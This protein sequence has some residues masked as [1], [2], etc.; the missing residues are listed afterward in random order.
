M[1]SCTSR[2]PFTKLYS[3]IASVAMSVAAAL[4]E[5]P[6]T[7]TLLKK[8]KISP[9]S[10]LL[11]FALPEHRRYLGSDPMLPTCIK[12]RLPAGTDV[13][14]TGEPTGENAE[15]SYSPISHPSNEDYF[16][17][18]VKSYPR[19]AGG[20]LGAYLCSLQVNGA[21]SSSDVP[22][23]ENVASEIIASVKK[24]RIMHGNPSVL[25]RWKHVGLVAGGTGI[26]PLYQIA[27]ILL[28]DTTTK[29]TD[30]RLL[31][32]NRHHKD[33]L[34]KD[35]LDRLAEDHPGR[36]QVTYSLT[37]P[38][39]NHMEAGRGTVEM[40]Q[41]AL[42]PPS[43]GDGST[44]ILICGKDGFVETWAGSVGRAPPKPDGSKG[45]KIQGPLLGL[46]KDAGYLS[47][48]V[49]KY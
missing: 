26:A 37:S 5:S 29:T 48:E 47:S 2:R 21:C 28:E 20:G 45:P 11:R 1:L 44:M 34:M 22:S 49:F 17:L 40:A 42:P 36:F 8:T 23:P 30:I 46:L 10:C 24:P 14:N 38:E 4:P 43:D 9:D 25:G 7:Y 31:F 3:V 39:N 27:K 35:E 41:R 19:C 18:L 12:V 33:I 32:I 13:Y 15:K 6:Q 16:D